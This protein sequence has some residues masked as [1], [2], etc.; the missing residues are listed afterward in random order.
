MN[1]PAISLA[2][3]RG[4]R[5]HTLDIAAEIERRGFSGIYCPSMGDPVALCQSIAHVT[6]E[7]PFGTAVQPIYFR[8]PVDLASTAAFIHELSGG[9]FWLGIGVTHGPVHRRLGISPGKPLS[10]IADYVASMESAA[11]Q[12]GELPPIVLAALRQ[13][14][15]ELAAEIGS[16]AVWA[17]ASRNDFANS[18]SHLGQAAHSDE[19]FV[20]NMIPTVIDEDR[21]AGAVRNRKTLAGYV[22]LENYRNYW[23]QAGWIEEMNAAEQAIADGDAEALNRAMTDD[24]LSN[25]TLYG[26]AGEVRDGVQAWFDAGCKTPILVPS[27][28]SGGQLKALEEVFDAFA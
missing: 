15:T 14:M 19:F 26:S 21:A 12:H 10:D 1:M 27:S 9:R 8:N 24:W 6:N 28:T 3:V 22:A 17:N 20:G 25:A 5:E 7:I 23:R 16:G 11:R 4:R 13:R 2:A 18:V